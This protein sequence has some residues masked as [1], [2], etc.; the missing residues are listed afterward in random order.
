MELSIV[1]IIYE[2]FPQAFAGLSSILKEFLETLE[3]F[4]ENISCDIPKV[5]FPINSSSFK[6]SKKLKFQRKKAFQNYLKV[7]FKQT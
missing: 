4:S 5:S 6:N 1:W 3:F 2:T 7:F